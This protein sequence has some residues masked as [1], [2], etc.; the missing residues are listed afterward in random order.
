MLFDE[1]EKAHPDVHRLLLQVL[2]DGRLTD[3]RGQVVDFRNA[4]V[5][6]TSN[7]G[8]EL[9][10][11][12]KSV[13]F[14]RSD[15]VPAAEQVLAA[16]RRALP[17]ELWNRIDETLVFQPLDADEIRRIARMLL[18]TTCGAAAEGRGVSVEVAEGVVELLLASGGYDPA[19]GARPMRRAIQRLVEAPLARAL[20]RPDLA[21]GTRL[22]I[23]ADGGML[24]IVEE[25]PST[26][27]EAAC[28]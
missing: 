11:E 23:V 15:A 16:A 17:P 3:G 14:G 9:F 2:E 28:A 4:V 27:G 22:R 26:Q 1:F 12:R 24:G 6:M 5:L 7:L 8:S 25:P 18:E 10:V 19:M 20:L 13:G 21:R